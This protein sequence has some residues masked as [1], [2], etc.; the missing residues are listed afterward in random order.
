MPGLQAN[1][2]GQHSTESLRAAR[3]WLFGFV[4][5]YGKRLFVIVLLS[6]F[7][8]GLGLAQPYITKFLIDDGL[9]ARQFDVVVWLCVLMICIGLIGAGLGAL[10]R[11]HYVDVSARILFA[12]RE[13]IFDHLQRLPPTFYARTRGGDLFA[14]LDGDIAEIQ[15][16]A[17]DSLLAFINGVFALVGALILM[18]TLSWQLSLLALVLLP[19]NFFFLRFIRPRVERPQGSFF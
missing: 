5:P 19:A 2:E 14:R 16:F 18:F 7:S 6:L 10:N 15:R 12:L 13:N 1:P 17:V 4:R 9:I 3:R 8:T 11:W